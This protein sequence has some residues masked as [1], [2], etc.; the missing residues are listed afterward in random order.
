VGDVIQDRYLVQNVLGRGGYGVTYLIE[1]L[2]LK[3]KRRALK[4]IPELLFDEHEVNLLSLLDHPSIPDIIDRFVHEGM[5]YLVLE[6]GGARTLGDECQRLG[7]RIPFPMLLPWIRQLC[8]S[9][10]YLH[11]QSPPIIHRDLK[12]ENILLSDT[13]RIMLIDFGIAKGF[14]ADDTT[15]VT[16]QAVS[17]GFS[18]PE[19]VLGSGTDERSDIYALGATLYYLLSGEV[20]P[21]AHER[22][23]GKELRTISD[24]VPGIP[25]AI[26]ELL[27][28]TLSLNIHYRPATVEEFR[29]VVDV[30]DVPHATGASLTN[31]TV[32]ADLRT[33]SGS[34]GLPLGQSIQGVKISTGEPVPVMDSDTL[35]EW[36][37]RRRLW[38]VLSACAIA[39]VLLSVAGYSY[40][41]REKTA[42][43]PAVETV[44]EATAKLPDAPKPEQPGAPAPQNP[45]A[46]QGSDSN[47]GSPLM[48]PVHVTLPQESD[49]IGG[50]SSV[51][52]AP[53]APA[54]GDMAVSSLPEGNVPEGNVP[55]ET[56]RETPMPAKTGIVRLPA[57]ME[58][59]PQVMSSSQPSAQD[60]LEQ[61]R[62]SEPLGTP[63]VSALSPAPAP[64]PARERPKPPV[65][66]KKSSQVQN[67]ADNERFIRN[68]APLLESEPRPM[69][70]PDAGRLP[71]FPNP[72]RLGSPW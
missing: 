64:A 8:E 23:A 16:A 51:A 37:P 65:S 15:R 44:K 49:T 10:S 26:D 43:S 21:P 19:Q 14:S 2:K 48:M 22:V 7:G 17:H 54:P 39:L 24:I 9:L 36:R 3:G 72:G 69:P 56:K 13:D 67:R 18:P 63:G 20:P 71:H 55:E 50:A 5:V 53:V 31:R 45:S 61:R 40:W 59:P 35:V 33:G 68:V 41:Q 70:G 66:Q 6:F 38:P 25:L 32:K 47:S 11:S 4:E 62:R 46:P 12:P 27:A 60:I 57:K 58:A 30:L 34:S 1:D 29:R 42:P 52:P 28:S